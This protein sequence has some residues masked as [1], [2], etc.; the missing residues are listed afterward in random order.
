MPNGK[1]IRKA[2]VRGVSSSAS[3]FDGTAAGAAEER[4]R[5]NKKGFEAMPRSLFEAFAT[6]NYMNGLNQMSVSMTNTGT[7]KAKDHFM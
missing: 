2:T 4:L 6:A 7:K 5:A 3:Q 1:G